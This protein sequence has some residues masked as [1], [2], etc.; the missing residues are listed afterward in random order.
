LLLFTAVV[1][2]VGGGVGCAL[3]SKLF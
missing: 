3:H 2:V 1:V